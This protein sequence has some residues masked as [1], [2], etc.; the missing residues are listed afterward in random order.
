MRFGVNPAWNGYTQR[1]EV[2]LNL[3]RG[4]SDWVSRKASSLFTFDD[5]QVIDAAPNV[6]AKERG[7][8]KYWASLAP[9][10]GRRLTPL[11]ANMAWH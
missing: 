4:A 2:W 11:R 6:Y 3:L 9:R 5:G 10:R 1:N 8:R 7:I